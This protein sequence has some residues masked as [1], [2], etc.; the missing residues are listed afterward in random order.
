[1]PL[2][3]QFEKSQSATT[4]LPVFFNRYR[5]SKC[6]ENQRGTATVQA[7]S[8]SASLVCPTATRNH[9]ARL[10]RAC[11]TTY[12]HTAVSPLHYSLEKIIEEIA[13]DLWI[14]RY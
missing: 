6:T 12:S 14:A 3:L 13:S 2:R 10:N 11:W 7:R 5:L 8:I 1:V 9:T 4:P